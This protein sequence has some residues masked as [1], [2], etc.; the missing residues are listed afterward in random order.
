MP[1]FT[2]KGP[3]ALEEGLAN[4]QSFENHVC[5]EDHRLLIDNAIDKLKGELHQKD[6]EVIQPLAFKQKNLLEEHNASMFRFE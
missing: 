6:I 2:D 4:D 3:F 5:L 1:I